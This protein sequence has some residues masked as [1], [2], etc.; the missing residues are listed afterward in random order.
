MSESEKDKL[1]EAVKN[2][3][4]SLKGNDM[5][6]IQADTEALMTVNQGITTRLYSEA[7]SDGAGGGGGDFV[8]DDE[9][10]DAEIVDE[11]A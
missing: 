3:K 9:V 1:Q 5:S 2:L 6:A 7:A 4:G 8:E 10:V 11:G